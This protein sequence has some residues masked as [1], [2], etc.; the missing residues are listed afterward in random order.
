M[1]CDEICDGNVVSCTII[2]SL[3]HYVTVPEL[4]IITLLNSEVIKKKYRKGKCH[5][6]DSIGLTA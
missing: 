6:N 4:I 1:Y 5:I 2:N 3:K